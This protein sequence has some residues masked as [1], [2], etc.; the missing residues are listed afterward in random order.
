MKFVTVN[1]FMA[2]PADILEILPQE[3]ELTVTNNGVPVALSTPLNDEN[4][5]DSIFAVRGTKAINAV[6]PMRR[7]SV[8]TGTDNMTSEEINREIKT[9]NKERTK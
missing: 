7:Q 5:E 8:R 9:S 2:S 6:K 1:D 3:R 4:L